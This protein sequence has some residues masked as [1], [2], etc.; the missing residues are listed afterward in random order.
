MNLKICDF[1]TEEIFYDNIQYAITFQQSAINYMIIATNTPNFSSVLI[2]YKW[3]DESNSFLQDRSIYNHLLFR[4]FQ[5]N[6]THKWKFSDIPPLYINSQITKLFSV[7][8]YNYTI[9]LIETLT[10]DSLNIQIL[11]FTMEYGFFKFQEIPSNTTLS[12]GSVE[13]DNQKCLIIVGFRGPASLYCSFKSQNNFRI[14]K[15]TSLYN[16]TKVCLFKC[17]KIL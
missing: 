13:T 2:I 3:S 10:E 6:K 11:N 14:N 12:V 5:I 9:I 8:V 17:S 16:I 15:L 1:K 7:E 4:L